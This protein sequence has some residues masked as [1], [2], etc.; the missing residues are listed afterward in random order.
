MRNLAYHDPLTGLPNRL[1]FHDR[2]DQAIERARRHRQLLAVMLLDLDRF[3]LINDS[4]GLESGDQV[5]RAVADRL[6]GR[7]GA[8]IRWRGSAA[9]SS[10]CCCSATDDAESRRQG[11]AEAARRLRPPLGRSTATSWTSAP[12]SASRCIPTTATTRTR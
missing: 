7:C 2:L 3:K 8:A 1:L 11:R 9:T 4:L 10:W 12:A 5:L 6:V